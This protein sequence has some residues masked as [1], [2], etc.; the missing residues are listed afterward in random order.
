M[1]GRVFD[2][3]GDGRAGDS[4]N[5]G[6]DGEGVARGSIEASPLAVQAVADERR[7]LP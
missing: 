2:S 5:E 1:R 7:Q 6:D 3:P 4:A